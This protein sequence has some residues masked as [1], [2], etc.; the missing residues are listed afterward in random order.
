MN[1]VQSQYSDGVTPRHHLPSARQEYNPDDPTQSIFFVC[2]E[3]EFNS[4]SAEALQSIYEHRH[5]LVYQVRDFD[6]IIF[7][8]DGLGRLES[9]VEKKDIQGRFR[10]FS[11][12]LI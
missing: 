6:P 8:E 4:M 9:L 1:S 3:K 11:A 12:I 10:N 2:T 5:I 7:D